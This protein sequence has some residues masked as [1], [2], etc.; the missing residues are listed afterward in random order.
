[1]MTGETDVLGE[2]P[3]SVPLGPPQI[4]HELWCFVSTDVRKLKEKNSSQ[5]SFQWYNI[6]TKPRENRP[7]G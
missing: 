2:N 3:V 4:L 5:G 1:M 7:P 6:Y